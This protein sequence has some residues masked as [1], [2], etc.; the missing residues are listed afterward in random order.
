MTDRIDSLGIQAA[1]FGLP[2]QIEQS[3][4]DSREI[5]GLP[6]IDNIDQ[7]LVLGMGGSGIAGDV[8]EAIAA[9]RMSIPVIVSKGY[10]CPSFVGRRTLVMAVSFSGETEE[11]LHAA[12]IAHDLGA[13]IVAVTGG[14]SLGDMARQWKSS[15]HLVC[16]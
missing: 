5:D 13:R 15:L 10:E 16:L 2:D 9:P 14:G 3:M 11:T 6:T 4:A 7:V 8:V 12:S 1:T